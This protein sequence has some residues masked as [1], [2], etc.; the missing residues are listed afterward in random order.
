MI[1]ALDTRGLI[2]MPE[3]F[4]AS[5][6]G[7]GNE[8]P[9]GARMSM[10]SSAIEANRDGLNALSR[11]T[12]GFPIFNNNDLSLGL[13]KIIADTEVYYLLAFEP[14][15]SYRDGRFRKLEV[16]VK[17]H[18]EYK[19][20]SSKGYFAPDD[21][22][23]V[24]ASEKEDRERAK[25]AAER[26]KN[27]DKAA[28]KESAAKVALVGN[29]YNALFPLRAIPT[30]LAVDY[31]D[32]GKGEG[33]ATLAAHFDVSGIKFEPTN[34]RYNATVEV[35]GTIYDEKGKSVDGFSQKLAMTLKL[36]TYERLVKSLI[37][38]FANGSEIDVVNLLSFAL[39]DHLRFNDPAGL[40]SQCA[41]YDE[42][43]AEK[44]R[45]MVTCLD[46]ESNT[47]M[48][49]MFDKNPELARKAIITAFLYKNP[50]RWIDEDNSLDAL[51]KDEDFDDEDEDQMTSG[52]NIDHL[53]D[54][55]GDE[56]V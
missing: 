47:A 3:A 39:V 48:N 24:K 28:K 7:F 15:V 22:A 41:V 33:Y 36:A 53:F 35:V 54:E 50:K 6:P 43:D 31:V 29:A 16:R 49:A 13:Q 44:V 4:D 18:P 55:R 51:Q 26:E 2:A 34:D 23:A 1:Y 11:D 8:Q 32:T 38:E 5:Q 25:L 46:E 21:K 45:K 52:H 12:G 56:N 20:R 30:E 42:G 37:G 14:L 27:P 17:N 10:E 9:P 40:L 19:V